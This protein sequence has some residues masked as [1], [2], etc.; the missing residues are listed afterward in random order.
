M[1]LFKKFA[2]AMIVLSVA[3][4]TDLDELLENPNGVDPSRADAV[5]LY[6]SVQLNFRNVANS[7][8]VYRF[9]AGLARM[10]GEIGGFTYQATHGPT[11]FDG[12]W[13]DVYADLFPDIDAFISLA[14]PIGLDTEVASAK[15]MKAYSLMLLVDL[16]ND[17]PLS[18]A[19]LGASPDNQILNPTADSGEEVYNAAIALLDEALAL[20]DG[21]SNF[22][23]ASFDNFYGGSVTGWATLAKTMKVRAAVTTRLVGGAGGAGTI[24]SALAE[25]DIIDANS[26]NFEF[27]YGNNRANPD[28]RHPFY[29]NAYE[30]SD[31]QY[32]SNWYMWLLAESKGFPDP[33]TRYYFYRQETDIIGAYEDDPNAFDCIQTMTP[34]PD[35]LPAW[36]EAVSEDMPYC[37]G[38][39]SQGYFGRDHLNGSGIPPDGQLRTVYGLYPGGGKFDDGIT[40][41]DVQNAG[42][43]G[44]QG[45]GIAP[46]WQASFTHFILAEA[47]LTMGTDGD[48]REFLELGIE[49]S[50]ERVRAFESLVDGS[51]Q[52][53]MAPPVDVFVEDT[54]PADSTFT[55]YVDYV[56]DEYDAASSDEERLGIVAR[57][58][59]IALYGNGIEAY[60]LYRRTCLPGQIQPAIDPN[61]G[62]F[63]RS[64]LY[65]SVHVNLNQNISQKDGFTEPVFWDTN[66]ASCNY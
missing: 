45:A 15:I 39:Y 9:T 61:P 8:T 29:P 12:L 26:E 20:L 14:E 33:R 35:F 2:L 23:S 24:N 42:V 16:F 36:Y 19:G 5:S 52:V 43:D 34:D 4:C 6:N 38:S 51:E 64:A 25:G 60:N 3:A 66:D 18:E 7:Q 13:N 30:A 22:A 1:N 28:N 50:Q 54:Y 46:L 48:A 41:D 21:G 49:L 63:I 40:N 62:A 44:A 57:E 27:Q 56:L 55:Q 32:L 11:E 37:L 47:A 17:V 59:L 65:P 58:Y 53:A 31:A 10:N